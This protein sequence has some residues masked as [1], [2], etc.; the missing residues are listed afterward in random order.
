MNYTLSLPLFCN[1]PR[2]LVS[3]GYFKFSASFFSSSWKMTPHPLFLAFLSEKFSCPLFWK[4][5]FSLYLLFSPRLNA[6]TH[7]H[8]HL[9]LIC[10]ICTTNCTTMLSL[11][12]PL[13]SVCVFPVNCLSLSL[14]FCLFCVT[15]FYLFGW[16]PDDDYLANIYLK[17]KRKHLSGSFP[18]SL[19]LSHSLLSL[20]ENLNLTWY[21]IHS[22]RESIFWDYRPGDATSS[23][24]V[25]S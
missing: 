16:L 12:P 14:P 7:T 10:T 2:F 3:I 24:V 19:S 5:F 6:C 18:I 11:S 20:G 25:P 1:L 9:F 21:P 4:N 17:S 23:S 22:R 13:L 15:L 8:T